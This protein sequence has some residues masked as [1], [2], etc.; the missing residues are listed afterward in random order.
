MSD[1]LQEGDTG[2]WGSSQLG[3][4]TA[5]DVTGQTGILRGCVHFGKR[6]VPAC[7]MEDPS[8]FVSVAQERGGL[9][10]GKGGGG[11]PPR[12]GGKR[13]VSSRC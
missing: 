13:E 12:R 9:F 6:K 5:A 1:A 7:G 3:V 4:R 11:G 2:H 8:V 10:M